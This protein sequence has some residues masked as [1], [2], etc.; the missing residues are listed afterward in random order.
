MNERFRQGIVGFPMPNPIDDEG[1]KKLRAIGLRP[2]GYRFPL[3]IPNGWFAVARS[4]DLSPGNVL[5]TRVFGRELVLYR[6]EDGK[7]RLLDA[8]C[9]HQGAH[10]AVGGR[11]EG[12]CI[13][14][15]FHGW[16]LDGGSGACVEVPWEQGSPPRQEAIRTY[17][18][19]EQD[20]AIFA[21]N[22]AAAAPPNFE[23]PRVSE[24]SNPEWEPTEYRS[25]DL[26]ICIQDVVENNIDQ[27]HFAIA[28][29]LLMDTRCADFSGP[30][31]VNEHG[32]GSGKIITNQ[33]GMG[34]SIVRNVTDG[35]D[36]VFTMLTTVTPIDTQN[37]TFRIWISAPKAHK[38]LPMIQEG[39]FPLLAQDF[40]IWDTKI[41][42][43]RPMITKDER[44]ILDHRK[45]CL[46]FYAGTGYTG[47]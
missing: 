45:W 39:L 27:M 16:K 15:P 32:I 38:S 24:F 7:P 5:A 30:C 12:A 9:P 21:W 22:H 44:I 13:R 8:Y 19:L 41:Y 42:R 20:G 36:P 43:S 34:G 1:R 46:Q 4:T 10:L 3:P 14:C 25:F 23:F 40:A 6:T 33:V 28:H 29:G 37:L 47:E 11:I 17:P 31:L 18:T 2:S 35:G 26:A